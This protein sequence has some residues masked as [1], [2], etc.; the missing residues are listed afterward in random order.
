MCDDGGVVRLWDL[1]SGG[2]IRSLVQHSGPVWAVALSPVA[3]H[4]LSGGEDKTLRILDVAR[5]GEVRQ[6][7]GISTTVECVAFSPDG[8]LVAAGG[9]NG[10]VY[11]GDT[12]T[13]DPLRVLTGH[14]DWVWDIAFAKDSRHAVSCGADGRLIYWDLDEKRA[15]HQVKL[16]GYTIRCLALQTDGRHVTFGA[17]RGDLHARTTGLIGDWDMTTDGPS[18]KFA[19]GL[20]HLGLAAMP[21]G[22][23]ATADFDG[24]VRVWEPSAAIA[25]ARELSR[26]GKRADA[27]PEYDKA[28][29][30]RPAD[31]RLLIERGRLLASLGQGTRANSDFESAARLA[32]D[33]PQFFLDAGWWVAGPYPLE[34]SQAGAL[35]NGSATD[36]SQPAPPLGSETL[37]WHEVVPGMSSII[38]FEEQFK[39]DDVVGYA[40]TVVYSTQPRE[41]VLLIGCDD[42]AKI[43]IN[44]REVFLETSYSPP[45]SRAFFAKLQSGRNTIVAKVRNYRQAH[46]FSLR[47]GES[48][49][50]HARAY[51][52]AGK[53]KEATEACSK[54]T[55]LD[56]ENWDR[57]TLENWARALAEAGRWKELKE[58]LEKIAALDPGNFNK[59]QDLSKCYLMIPDR[60]AYERL[61]NAALKLHGKT[62]D[63]GQANNLIWLVA[64]MPDAV[65]NY[66]EFVNIGRKLVNHRN[67]APN[68]CNTFG[69]VLYRAGQY[70]GALTYLKRSI[71]AADGNRNVYDWLFTAMA[72]HKSKQPGAREALATAK[73]LAEKFPTSPWQFRAERKAL[74]EEAE[75]ELS[76]PPPR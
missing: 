6:F 55:A 49:F 73:A 74:F 28:V 35:E 4:V 1:D 15:L 67:P 25:K 53:S 9:Q 41:A 65:R 34:Y 66:T 7:E 54:A 51:L 69:G 30:Q 24:L 13:S 58:P 63:P 42:T 12:R 11:V 26:A 16:D 70:A 8:R 10:A 68:N 43:R 32:P 57:E 76:L 17:Q 40:M 46:G 36:P 75:K 52:R 45:D 48:P 64:L 44:G 27:L 59:Q 3:P 62:Q 18:R 71:D 50:D 29:V 47:F 19:D 56:P 2:L 39:G 60:E 33:S 72:R 61:C 14:T 22:A 37:R 20:S 31:A 5:A 23:F 21:H 38:N